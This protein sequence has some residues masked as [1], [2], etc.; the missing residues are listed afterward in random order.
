MT[1]LGMTT[2]RMTIPNRWA[3][4]LLV[5]GVLAC[6]PVGSARLQG[7]WRGVRA[8]GVPGDA[9]ASANSF[10]FHTQLYFQGYELTAVFPHQA[11]SGRYRIVR[12]DPASLVLTTDADGPSAPE[13]F[14][15]AADGTMRW[16][17]V[18]GRAIIF[19]HE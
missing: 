15:F 17:I 6:T 12:E 16:A 3:L 7:R 18:P 19:A 11:Q 8:E 1:T 10:A 9:S 14:T 5:L 2:S 4:P 13:T